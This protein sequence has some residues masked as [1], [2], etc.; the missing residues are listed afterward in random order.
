MGVRV[1]LALCIAYGLGCLASGF[2]LVRLQTGIDLRTLGSGSTGA[3]N[4]GRVLGRK[5]FILTMLLDM[6][7]GAV[8][9]GVG[10]LLGLPQ[11][12]LALAVLAAVLGHVFP[13]QLG[14][15][16]GKGLATGFGALVVYDWRLAAM[17]LVLA[18]ALA[19]LTRQTTLSMMA[20][21]LV[22]PW[23]ALSLHHNPAAVGGLTL[24]LLVIVYAH[25]TNMLKAWHA[26][27]GRE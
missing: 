20:V 5:G 26:W 15:R 21:L 14:C 22:V 8:A 24:T 18:G 12:W 10:L 3:T 2:W 7:K 16:G 6:G 4:A 11:S 19:L 1:V 27:R 17:V 9:I 23:M 25:R 13:V